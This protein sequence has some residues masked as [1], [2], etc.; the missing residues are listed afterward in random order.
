MNCDFPVG[1]DDIGASVYKLQRKFR[2]K[3]S[4]LSETAKIDHQVLTFNEANSLELIEKSDLLRRCSQGRNQDADPVGSAGILCHRTGRQ[5][6]VV[7]SRIPR[8]S[9]RA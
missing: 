3:I 7:P 5:A 1:H 6:A 4:L 2:D 9:L 8:K